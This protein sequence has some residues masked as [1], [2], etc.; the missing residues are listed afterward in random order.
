M[1]QCSGSVIL[2][3]IGGQGLA[4][5]Q[6]GGLL[7]QSVVVECIIHIRGIA[8]SIVF[9]RRDPVV[10]VG[11]C[12]GIHLSVIQILTVLPN[13]IARNQV[14]KAAVQDLLPWTAEMR[15]NTHCSV[16]Y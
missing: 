10:A 11:E 12:A 8:G 14:P 7:A 5:H 6:D 4:S 16:D 15:Q 3:V 13:R 2:V 9:Y 1:I